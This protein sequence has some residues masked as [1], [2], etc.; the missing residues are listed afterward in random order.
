MK[1]RKRIRVI[2]AIVAVCLLSLA[3][4]PTG[5][6]NQNQVFETA[7][8]LLTSGKYDEALKLYQNVADHPPTPHVAA[9]ALL[10]KASAVGLY[11]KQTE[12]ALTLLAHIQTEY[13][14]SPAAADALFH[15]GMLYYEQ[16]KYQ[17]AVDVFTRYSERYPH[18]VRLRS[19]D[20]W[21]K[22]STLRVQTRTR[23][24]AAG[25]FAASP[26]VRVLMAQGAQRLD[27]GAE[28][29]LVVRDAVT[30]RQVYR[31]KGPVFFT[32]NANRL[33]L[34]H[35]RLASRKCRIEAD[36]GLLSFENRQW[37]GEFTVALEPDGLQA[38]N[39]LHVEHYLY[40]IVPKEM[41]H[42]W[43]NDALKAQ[44][45][46]A[47]TYVLHIKGNNHLMPF[48]VEA[49]TASQVYGGY[50][51]ETLKTNRAV[52]ETRNQV[53]THAG[54]LII[55]YF[56]ANSAGYTENARH[57]WQVDYPYLQGGPDPYSKNIPN[58]RWRYALS[59][60]TA[61]RKLNQAGLN[62]G[63]IQSIRSL[64]HTQTGR[65]LEVG[66]D[67]ET[68][69]TVLSANHFRQ[70][71]GAKR[72][73]STF[74]KF[75]P[76]PDGVLVKGKGYGHGVGMSQWG[77]NRMAAAGHTY[78]EILNHYY[79]GSRLTTVGQKHPPYPTDLKKGGA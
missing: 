65:V 23:G 50:D 67:S 39:H 59:F 71:L 35:R 78:L 63:S 2:L 47:R 73:K 62:V 6:V 15:M 60:S 28:G 61:T 31:A 27:M 66:V 18:G 12:A 10:L 29:M 13:P 52:D 7:A 49:T 74:F 55:A 79:P 56:H 77:A 4:S 32:R 36:G 44:A 17:T 46:A 40:G 20:T 19:A 5:A 69:S 1:G 43:P 3:P 21:R 9:Q 48:D 51:E 72:I 54:R 8:R 26:T 64:Q 45:V 30:G 76:T 34:N 57:V 14:N 38:I 22:S 75:V 41:P 25:V 70:L 68:G 58:S 37:R 42:N 16:G 53:L 11:L 24:P 33:Y